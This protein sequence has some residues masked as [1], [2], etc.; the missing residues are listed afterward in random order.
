MSIS[1]A[2]AYSASLSLTLKGTAAGTGAVSGKDSPAKPAGDP[3]GGAAGGSS[4]IVSLSVEAQMV[5]ASGSAAAATESAPTSRFA[6]YFPTRD[7]KPV[8]ALA[9]AVEN[10][11]AQ[12][13]SAG[14]TLPE[15]AKD[16]RARMDAQYDAMK[17]SGKPFDANA[18]EGRDWNTV[19]GDLDRRSLYAISS[20]TGGLFSEEEQNTARS[21]MVQQQGLAM[22]LYSGPTRLA[23]TFSD[24]F[25]GDMAAHMKAGV[26]FLDGVSDEEKTSVDWAMDR[27]GAQSNYEAAHRNTREELEALNGET[28]LQKLLKAAA[29]TLNGRDKD[30]PSRDKTD[31]MENL[32]SDNPLA[33]LVK[34]AVDTMKG[35]PTRGISHGLI[36]TAE[37]LK[38]QPWFKGFESQLDTAIQQTREMYQSR[39]APGTV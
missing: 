3:A 7:G 29:K 1:T 6:A 35:N 2:T 36:R 32:D 12:S 13:S 34:T 9:N 14:L 28:P 10:P 25:N 39:K 23:G 37:D 15:A 22:G 26:K 38:E 4:V 11:G 18:F 5:V 30:K 8:T 21:M 31:E 20:N 33:K 24:P 16:A 19:M 17:A 27:A